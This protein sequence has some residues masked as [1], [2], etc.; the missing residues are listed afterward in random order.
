MNRSRWAYGIAAAAA[1]GIA[2]FGGYWWGMRRGM[3]TEAQADASSKAS[4]HSGRRVGRLAVAG[5]PGSIV[6]SSA[7]NNGSWDRARYRSNRPPD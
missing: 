3:E 4:A 7:I 2:L 1:L 6:V 5:I